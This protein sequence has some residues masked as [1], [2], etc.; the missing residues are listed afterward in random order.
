[1]DKEQA[2]FILQSFRPDGADASD[3][4]FAEALQLAAADRELGE[5][6]ADE[7][8]ADAAFAAALCEVEIPEELRQHILAVMRGEKPADPE[9]E[10]AMDDLLRDALAL[11]PAVDVGGI[12]EIEAELVAPVHDLIAVLF[13]RLRTK[14]HGSQA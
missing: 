9:I 12:E 10:A 3:P 5:W 14:V 4:S 6:L 8:S 13:G 11:L 1:M 2:Q 7:R